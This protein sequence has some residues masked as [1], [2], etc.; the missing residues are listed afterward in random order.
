MHETRKRALA[1]ALF[2]CI[3]CLG[4]T[5]LAQPDVVAAA[6]DDNSARPLPTGHVRLA[7]FAPTRFGV[8][9]GLELSTNPLTMWMFPHLDAKARIYARRALTIAVIGRLSYPTLL[10]DILAREGSLGLLPE[11]SVVPPMLGIDAELTA[12]VA[13]RGGHLLSSS[14]GILTAPRFS[15]GDFALLDFPF[16]YGRFA[17]TKTFATFRSRLTFASALSR[18]LYQR[19]DISYTVIPLRQGQGQALQPAEFKAGFAL[20]PTAFLGFALS[21]R[22]LVEASLSAHAARLPVGFRLHWLPALDLHAAF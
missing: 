12:S 20:E 3:L 19:V 1:L 7:L 16:L 4:R 9:Q 17:Q 8:T 21:R 10:L 2:S 6:L 14:W 22:W 5:A 18:R 13:L 15:D 11:N